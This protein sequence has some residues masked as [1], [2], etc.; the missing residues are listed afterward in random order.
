MY[1][2]LCVYVYMDVNLQMIWPGATGPAGFYCAWQQTVRYVK[3]TQTGQSAP[4]L[5][6][7][8]WCHQRQEIPGADATGNGLFGSPPTSGTWLTTDDISFLM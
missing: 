1:V 7:A 8:V 5:A 4:L 6:R 3:H 2:D